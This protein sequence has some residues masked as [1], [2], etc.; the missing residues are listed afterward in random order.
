MSRQLKRVPPS[1]DW[2][3]HEVWGGYL[4]PY[5]TQAASCPDCLNGYDRLGGRPDANA[6]LFHEQWYGKVPFDPVTYGAEPISP[7][8]PA[9][10]DL[11]RRNV[12]EDPDFYMTRDEAAERKRFRR[13]A[14]EG[15]PSDDRPL[16][17][18]PSFDRDAAISR[19]AR[20]LYD[21]CFRGHWSHH[22]IQADVDALLECDRLWDFTMVPRDAAQAL[23]VAIRMSFHGT[24]SWL[25]ES[26]GYHPTA[27]EVNAWSLHGLS[28]DS[29]NASIC[30]KAR[31]A[32]EGIPF[33]CARCA[34][35]GTIWPMPE[36]KQLHDEWKPTEPPTGDGYQLWES[37]TEGSPVS[38]VFASLEDLCAWAE[39]NATTFG[40]FRAS[41]E[42]WR[43]ML[44]GGLVY[45]QEGNAIFL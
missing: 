13:D 21:Q 45:H 35:S 11:A 38:P 3:L 36:I 8:D 41:K 4:N 42:E 17:P 37:C 24:N 12:R 30:I 20:R 15:F 27:S 29:F 2:P 1:F 28:H 39:T 22:L 7:L 33:S 14:M 34:G 10:W 44:D 5:A 31:C 40:S 16:I 25:P 32:R 19:E 6:A 23:V 18:F 9:I 43:E 26:N